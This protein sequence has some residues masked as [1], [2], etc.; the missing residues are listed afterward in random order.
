LRRYYRS[1]WAAEAAAL[2]ALLAL[3]LVLVVLWRK[4]HEEPVAPLP[5]PSTLPSAPLPIPEL[6]PPQRAAE[7][8]RG[9]LEKCAAGAWEECVRGLD[10]AKE[11]DPAADADPIVQ[12]ARKQAADARAVP[13][14]KDPQPKPI[15]SVQKPA[16][17]KT[18]ALPKAS[19]L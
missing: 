10:A 2:A 13:E 17:R 14:S 12:S 9:A 19:S 16:P 15:P 1:R 8:R 3:T 11:L 6:L 4:R 7:L 18:N 5:A